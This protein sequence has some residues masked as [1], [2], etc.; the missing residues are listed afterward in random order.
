MVAIQLPKLAVD[1]VEM[2]VGEEFGDGVDVIRLLQLADGGEKGSPER[3]RIR[4]DGK[5]V[6]GYGRKDRG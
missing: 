1:D 4:R 5:E 6:E 3:R 2:F